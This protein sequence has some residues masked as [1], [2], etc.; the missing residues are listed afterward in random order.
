[1]LRSRAWCLLIQP[2]KGLQQAMDLV[3]YLVETVVSPSEKLEG[4]KLDIGMA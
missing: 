2:C 1:V 4:L 3:E